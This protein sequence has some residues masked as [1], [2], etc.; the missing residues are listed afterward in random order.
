MVPVPGVVPVPVASVDLDLNLAD[1]D[2]VEWTLAA[3][4]LLRLVIQLV[5]L[6]VYASR[7]KC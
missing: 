7:N 1:F 4:C 6:S 3:L 2:A 5:K